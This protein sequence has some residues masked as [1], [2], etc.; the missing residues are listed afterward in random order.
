MASVS[1][2]FQSKNVDYDIPVT[3]VVDEDG[4][5]VVTDDIGE[6]RIFVAG[7]VL[8]QFLTRRAEMVRLAQDAPAA[9]PDADAVADAMEEVAD[10]GW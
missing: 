3:F 1:R 10:S 5:L 4:D 7:D 9:A 6:D 8:D 2:N